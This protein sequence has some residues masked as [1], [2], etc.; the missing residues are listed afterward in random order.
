[1]KH[2][3]TPRYRV[4]AFYTIA[5]FTALLLGAFS[6]NAFAQ[7]HNAARALPDSQKT[8]GLEPRLFLKGSFTTLIEPTPT[9]QAAVEHRLNSVVSLQHELGYITAYEVDGLRNYWGL[10]AR[11]EVRY[12][13]SPIERS[14]TNH[15]F[16]AEALIKYNYSQDNFWY[17]AGDYQ[18]LYQQRVLRNR[19]R[20]TYGLAL[21]YGFMKLYEDRFLIDFVMGMGMKHASLISDDLPQDYKNISSR[22]LDVAS[23]TGVLADMATYNYAINFILGLKFGF[24]LK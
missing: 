11:S 9:F 10:R 4:S 5:I 8:L 19:S 14:K 21:E 1:M 20:M 2:F 7:G 3:K 22:D 16:A 15:Y 6:Q 17:C 13:T 18:C 12:Y 24:I 23:T